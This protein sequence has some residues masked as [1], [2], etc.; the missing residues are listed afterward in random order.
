MR[1]ATL[2]KLLDFI[3]PILAFAAAIVAVVGAPKWD[4]AATGFARITPLGWLVLAIGTMALT[5]SI[6]LTV[7]NRRDHVKQRETREQ[8]TKI[9]K[10]HLL[11][12]M[13]HAI[14]PFRDS[15]IWR[16]QC[17]RPESPL[18]LLNSDRRRILASLNLNS[19]SSYRN[20]T[21]DVVKWHSL[22]ERAAGKGVQEITTALQ[23]YASHLPSDIMEAVTKLL[24]SRFMQYRLLLIHD[25][26]DANTH[27]QPDRPVLFF[28]VSDDRMHTDEYEEFW[29]LAA[30]AMSACGADLDKTGR[31]LFAR[32]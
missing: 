25:I 10:S 23:I 7:R 17:E 2:A 16:Q 18:D 6:L 13:N 21:F 30:A 12:A 4:A 28:W 29:Q 24:Y 22:L 20:G 31:P 15:T 32:T 9:A 3:P 11:R 27:G 19:D 14:F 26:I 5:A 1:K 8:I